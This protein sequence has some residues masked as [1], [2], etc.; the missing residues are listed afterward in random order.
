MQI[1]ISDLDQRV[2]QIIISDLDQRVMRDSQTM[3]GSSVLLKAASFA[4]I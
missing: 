4:L 2:V 1:I 3:P